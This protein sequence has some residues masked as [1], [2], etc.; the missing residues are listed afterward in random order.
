M[1]KAEQKIEVIKQVLMKRYT[2]LVDMIY[3]E[4]CD[5]DPEDNGW[6]RGRIAGYVDAMGLLDESLESLRVELEK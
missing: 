6:Y 2:V 5:M 4:G 1:N 3:D